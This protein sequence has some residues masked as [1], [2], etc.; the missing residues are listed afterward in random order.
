MTQGYTEEELK[1]LIHDAIWNELP[2]EKQDRDELL[3]AEQIQLLDIEGYNIEAL[4]QD[5]LLDQFEYEVWIDTKIDEGEFMFKV[6][7]DRG[8]NHAKIL[9]NLH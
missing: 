7:E 3:Q 5:R 2:D 6:L 9:L 4:V 1:K 8:V